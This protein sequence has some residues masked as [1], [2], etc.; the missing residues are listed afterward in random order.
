[1]HP[2]ML[3]QIASGHA[4][5]LRSR[6]TRTTRATRITRR[7]TSGGGLRVWSSSSSP[8]PAAVTGARVV[9][10][11]QARGSAKGSPRPGCSPAAASSLSSTQPA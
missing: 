7:R 6:A 2:W 5:D 1:M 9:P 3:E 4:R 10:I 8:T 11:S